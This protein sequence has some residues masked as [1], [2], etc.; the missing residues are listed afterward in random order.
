MTRNYIPDRPV[1]PRSYSLRLEEEERGQIGHCRR[2]GKTY[3]CPDC[4]AKLTG[5]RCVGCEAEAHA[6]KRRKMNDCRCG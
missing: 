4:G 3:R 5:T 6:E 1:D 2:R